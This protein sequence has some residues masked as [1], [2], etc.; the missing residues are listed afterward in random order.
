MKKR[1]LPSKGQVREFQAVVWNHYR[2]HGRHDL[3][4]RHTM[5]PYRIAV[6]EVMLQQTQVSRVIPKYR[7]FLNQ[8]PNTKRLA[9]ADLATVL[10]LWQGLGYNRRAKMLWQCANMVSQQRAGRWPRTETDLRALPGIGVYTARAILVFAYRQ[11]VVLLETN[12]RTVYLY[13]FFPDCPSVSDRALSEVVELALD[14]KNAQAWYWALMDYGTY[15]KR[16]V[17]N[18]NHRSR[19]YSAQSP[20][21]GSDRE[22]RGA[23]VRLLTQ[24]DNVALT[25]LCVDLPFTAERIQNQLRALV[26]EGLVVI[27]ND[28]V[29]LPR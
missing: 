22:I 13:H 25:S 16:Q 2:K 10:R 6:S 19:S 9:D 28:S 14:M 24:H 27:H 15:L 20:F 3:P 8:F 26:T 4:W 12:I 5:D 17:G 21:R 18:Q 29:R 11:P 23:I 1:S 7:A